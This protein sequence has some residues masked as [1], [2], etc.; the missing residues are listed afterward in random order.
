MFQSQQISLETKRLPATRNESL[1]RI[2]EALC[3]GVE[4]MEARG[5]IRIKYFGVDMPWK[6]AEKWTKV[7]KNMCYSFTERR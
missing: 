3:V 2:L 7:P 6:T 5:A 4:G 1:V